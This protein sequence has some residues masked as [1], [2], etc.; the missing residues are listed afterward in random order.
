LGVRPDRTPCVLHVAKGHFYDQPYGLPDERLEM[1]ILETFVLRTLEVGRIAFAMA[2]SA[3]ET[4]FDYRP[5]LIHS[6]NA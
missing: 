6:G 3:S 2:E 1:D 4:P 5:D